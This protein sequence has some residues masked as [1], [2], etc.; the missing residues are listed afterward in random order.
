MAQARKSWISSFLING[1]FFLSA[2]ECFCT[3]MDTHTSA[4]M[5]DLFFCRL[6]RRGAIHF[7]D[8]CGSNN[9][10]RKENTKIL[11]GTWRDSFF[12]ILQLQWPMS[13]IT[14][15]TAQGV[16]EINTLKGRRRWTRATGSACFYLYRHIY[17]ICVLCDIYKDLVGKKKR[18]IRLD[19]QDC[20][21]LPALCAAR[22]ERRFHRSD[23]RAM[24]VKDVGLIL[25]FDTLL[26]PNQI[27]QY[28]AVLPS[29]FQT[30][31]KRFLWKLKVCFLFQGMAT[32]R[33]SPS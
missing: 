13:R 25:L 1:C 33:S 28:S 22:R 2:R 15:G 26:I 8:P 7:D 6:A 30:V 12:L 16:R 14:T 27:S 18:G 20:F 32:E 10:K 4:N 19:P 23:C 5:N 29:Y 24:V 3:N 9:T 31:W 11:K 17:P 21:E